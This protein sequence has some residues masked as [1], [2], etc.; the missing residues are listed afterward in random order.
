LPFSQTAQT[1]TFPAGSY[2]G[3]SQ[4]LNI[5]AGLNTTYDLTADTAAFTGSGV[6]DL[7][8]LF[9]HS[10][11]NV[12][13]TGD[14]VVVSAFSGSCEPNCGNFSWAGPVSGTATLTYTY[15]ALVAVP[16]P[17]SAALFGLGLLG[18]VAAR[19]RKALTKPS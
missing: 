17:S 8:V 2:L 13:A 14:G 5:L 10:L 15:A 7:D 9:S 18:A 1:S 16:E 12:G 11:F 19:R 6:I 4:N 3:A